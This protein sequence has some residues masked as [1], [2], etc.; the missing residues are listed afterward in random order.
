MTSL[1]DTIIS[2][3]NLM[4]LDNMTNYNRPAIDYFHHE[5]NNASLEMPASWKLLLKMRKHKLLRL[6]SCSSEDSLDYNMYL[7]RLH[8]CLW[9]RWSIN[10]YDLQSSKSNPLSINWNKETDVTV[11]YGPDLT[12]IDSIEDK[13]WPAQDS[14][15]RKEATNL[16]SA[17]KKNVESW[18]GD[19]EEKASATVEDSNILSEL[20]DISCASS[21]DS[22]TSSIFDQHSTC[23]KMSSVGEEDMENLD[24]EKKLQFPRKL[25]FNQ[26]VTRREIDSKGAIHESLVNINDTH[27]PRRHRHRHHRHHQQTLHANP[28]IKETYSEFD[29]YS[30]GAMENEDIFHR[31]QVVF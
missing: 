12:N 6:P 26:A 19:E 4:L 29:K 28:G 15:K 13:M 10:Q 9:R 8:H 30:F 31:N 2:Y 5:F 24:L 22:H 14:N 3:Q 16:K 20:E 23:T 1:D 7:V 18:V 25:K 11:L 21:V 17:L 27:H